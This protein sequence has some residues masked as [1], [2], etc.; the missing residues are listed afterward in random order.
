MAFGQGGVPGDFIVDVEQPIFPQLVHLKIVALHALQF[1]TLILL[2]SP[3]ARGDDVRNFSRG[4]PAWEG[5][6]GGLFTA[7][8]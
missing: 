2:D 4:D 8:L 1:A 7:S 3:R 5:L 6:G